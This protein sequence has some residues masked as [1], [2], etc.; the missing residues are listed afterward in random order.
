MH[1][2]FSSLLLSN[3]SGEFFLPNSERLAAGRERATASDHSPFYEN[4]KT[5]CDFLPEFIIKRIDVSSPVRTLSSMDL[6]G[7]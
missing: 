6:V 3:K 1:F 4:I 7:L 2:A 5:L